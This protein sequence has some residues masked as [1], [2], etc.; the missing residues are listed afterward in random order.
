MF[1]KNPKALCTNQQTVTMSVHGWEAE[2]ARKMINEALRKADALR[3]SSEAMQ[4]LIDTEIPRVC[5][6]WN[7]VPGNSIG[8][9][10]DATL[11]DYI[12]WESLFGIDRC[13][14][15]LLFDW[16]EQY[17]DAA[18]MVYSG[19]EE[20]DGEWAPVRLLVLALYATPSNH[21]VDD[22]I[23]VMLEQFERNDVVDEALVRQK[24]TLLLLC[25]ERACCSNVK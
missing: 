13:A 23:N 14:T 16:Y 15:P 22:A 9:R 20:G 21:L 3:Q 6:K 4:H 18:R 7:I 5:A 2:H 11:F 24:W 10:L 19:G 8:D 17:K 1:E 12:E 25:A